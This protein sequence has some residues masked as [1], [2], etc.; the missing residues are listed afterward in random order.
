MLF[1]KSV[2]RYYFKYWYFL[3][4]GA[5]AL[6][7][8]DIAQLEIPNIT[9]LIIDGISDKTLTHEFLL[10]SIL[11]LVGI[12]AIMFFGRFFWRMNIFNC[13]H[14]IAHDLRLR[15]FKK[16]EYLDQTYFNEYKTGAQMALYTND[17]ST[18]RQCF[19]QS[20]MMLVDAV[21]LGVL[22]FG[23]MFMLNK[24]LAFI[25]TAPL[26]LL[27]IIG[28]LVSKYMR[29]KWEARQK[30][31]SDLSD[32]AQENFSGFS[33][34]KAFVKETK[35]LMELIAFIRNEFKLTILLIEHDMKLVMGICERLYVLNYGRVLASGVPEE[36]KK[37][38]QVIKAY[39][40][41]EAETLV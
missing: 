36:I 27:A 16:M 8:V 21:F 1:G 14:R 40:G 7:V 25:A 20:I 22:A 6:I 23:K 39:L 35:E 26:L 33:V 37:D 18:V 17:L 5:L 24:V 13:G 41:S 31:Y 9:G 29:S 10:E 30:A 12:I 34:V 11:K 28:I 2:N 38:P 4:M 3:L 19:S 32:F 15:M